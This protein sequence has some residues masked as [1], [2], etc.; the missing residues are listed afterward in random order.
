M[1]AA[2]IKSSAKH[3]W[4]LTDE[5]VVLALFDDDTSHKEKNRIAKA[6]LKIDRTTK[7][8]MSVPTFPA[9]S[10]LMTSP[11]LEKFVGERSWLMFDKVSFDILYGVCAVNLII[12]YLL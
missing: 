8:R 1:V 3:S 10:L 7:I 12:E 9:R 11:S 4:Y 5:L 6:L 2:A